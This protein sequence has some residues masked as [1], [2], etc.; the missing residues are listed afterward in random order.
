MH[1]STGAI[2]RQGTYPMNMITTQDG[3]QI[4]FNDQGTGQPVVPAFFKS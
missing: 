2:H 3:T 4:H 1:W